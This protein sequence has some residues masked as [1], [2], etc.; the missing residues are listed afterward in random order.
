MKALQATPEYQQ[1]LTAKDT[2]KQNE[3]R[4]A[5]AKPDAKAFGQRAITLH[6]AG[7]RSASFGG[8]LL[9]T[10]FNV[11]MPVDFYAAEYATFNLKLNAATAPGRAAG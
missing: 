6:D 8:R 7:M 4:Q 2:A 11:V 5:V 3:L 10:H 1:A 9:R